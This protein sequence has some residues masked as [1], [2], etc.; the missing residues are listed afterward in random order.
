MELID[1]KTGDVL[2]ID[3]DGATLHMSATRYRASDLF[4]AN[5]QTELVARPHLV[6]HLDIAHRGLGT[7]SC[8]P[9]TLPH[10]QIGTGEFRFAYVVSLLA[11]AKTPA[12]RSAQKRR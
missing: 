11:G 12:S 4:A 2:R 8:G 5:D 6:I 10:Y 7:A 3:A 1:P 9:D